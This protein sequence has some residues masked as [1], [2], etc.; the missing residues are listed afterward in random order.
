MLRARLKRL[1]QFGRLTIISPSGRM[2]TFGADLDANTGPEVTIRMVGRLTPI[3]LALHP[4][5]YFGEAY[6]NGELIIEQGTLW[7]LLELCGRNL[8]RRQMRPPIGILRFARRMARAAT[9]YN[10]RRNAR[11]NAEHHY[12]LSD[13][14]YRLFSRQGPAIFLRLFPISDSIA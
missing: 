13:E 8:E 7:D 5:F 6:M 11:R 1:V 4:D 14:F 12:D 10:S 3:K 9:Q 2:T